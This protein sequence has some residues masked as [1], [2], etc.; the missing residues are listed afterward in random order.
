MLIQKMRDTRKWVQRKFRTLGGCNKG[1]G[2]TAAL[3]WHSFAASVCF[4]NKGVLW[5]SSKN[6]ALWLIF[7]LKVQPNLRV[8]EL[9]SEMVGFEEEK[10]WDHL[11]L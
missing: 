3:G 10:A 5:L 4:L 1:G 9:I 11:I 2:Y 6:A 7:L 8:M